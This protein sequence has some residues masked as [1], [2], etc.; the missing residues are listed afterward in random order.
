VSNPKRVPVLIVGDGPVG[1]AL[2]NALG[3]R[4]IDCLVIERTTRE[5]GMPLTVERL[6]DPEI[7]ELY[8]RTLVLVRPDGIVA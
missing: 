1:L 7:R 3:Q 8:G 5:A 2:A 6:R 4:G